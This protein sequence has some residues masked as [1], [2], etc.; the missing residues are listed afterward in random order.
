MQTIQAPS[1]L[2]IDSETLDADNADLQNSICDRWI[3]KFE[4]GCLSDRI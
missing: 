3:F 4:N 1:V 2:V